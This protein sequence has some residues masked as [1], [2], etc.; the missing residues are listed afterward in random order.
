MKNF[1]NS[2][3][4]LLLKKKLVIITVIITLVAGCRSLGSIDTMPAP[5]YKSAEVALRFILF[6]RNEKIT[7]DRLALLN[8]RT[9]ELHDLAYD[10]DDTWH[11]PSLPLGE[12][13]LAHII[14]TYK[15]NEIEFSMY[16]WT[17]MKLSIT[18][19]RKYNLGSL[20]LNTKVSSLVI[21]HEKMIYD[22]F[23]IAGTKYFDY[24]QH[25]L[26]ETNVEFKET[27]LFEH[28]GYGTARYSDTDIEDL[29]AA[30]DNAVMYLENRA[31][32]YAKTIKE[33]YR[34][35]GLKRAVKMAVSFLSRDDSILYSIARAEIYADAGKYNM[36][37]S[38]FA[39]II[40]RDPNTPEYFE[41]Q[42]MKELN[43]GNEKG[44]STNLLRAITLSSRNPATY[45]TY[46]RILSASGNHT[47]AARYIDAAVYYAPEDIAT[48]ETAA[49]I[50]SYAGDL[51]RS[52]AYRIK[53]E[54]LLKERV[55]P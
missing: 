37:D 53:I 8:L 2:Q 33:E 34:D 4:K 20:Q 46:A 32:D 50:Y 1:V 16:T 47:E 27:P 36:A 15:K 3:V 10:S 28:S 40:A 55:T 39:E 38:A 31:R 18:E 23:A 48:L 6:I 54:S 12:Y 22:L 25:R 5:S 35:Y 44:A 9:F 42:G 45:T 17:N 51:K 13:Q 24:Q 41:Y 14:A 52:E 30:L 26:F 43:S 19:S 29:P 21:S 49:E 11:T 7:P